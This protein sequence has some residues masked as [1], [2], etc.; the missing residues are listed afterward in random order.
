MYLSFYAMKTLIYLLLCPP[1]DAC[2]LARGAIR[3]GLGILSYR[4]TDHARTNIIP[5][6]HLTVMNCK[7]ILVHLVTQKV[8]RMMPNTRNASKRKET[9]KKHG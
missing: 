2:V 5:V 1:C 6:A 4:R 9:K 8:E 3:N 7:E